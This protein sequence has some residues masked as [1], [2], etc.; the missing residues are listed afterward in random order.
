MAVEPLL[1]SDPERVHDHRLLARLGAG[2]MGVVYLGRS[3]GGRAVAIKVIRPRFAGDAEYR[4]RFRREAAAARTVTGTF[5]AAV[6]DADPEAAEP[7]LVTA[8]LPGLT[9][10]Q[11]IVTF[12][13]LPLD[14]V[15]TL[16]AGLAESL[17][18]IHRAGLAH[19]DLKPGNIVLTASGPRVIDFGIARQED[20]TAITRAGTVLGTPGFM[21]PEQV[22]GMVAGTAADVF[23]L[24]AVV[25]FA[26]TGREPFGTGDT[27]VVLRRV[28]AA[29]AD[30]A[31]IDD[32]V[33]SDLLATCLRVDQRERPPAVALLDRLGDATGATDATGWLPARVAEAID[34]HAAAARRVLTLPGGGDEPLD[35]PAQGASRS[36]MS[37]PTMDPSVPVPSPEPRRVSRRTVLIG[38]GVAVAAGA[39][40]GAVALL[41]DDEHRAAQD[42]AAR[43]S[44][45]GV[46]TRTGAAVEWRV[47]V[48]TSIPQLYLAGGTVLASSWGSVGIRA[49]DPATGALA[50]QR[51]AETVSATAGD[52]ALLVNPKGW[53]VSAVDGAT[54]S[55][56]WTYDP[57]AGEVSRS[58]V[59]AGSVVC[60]GT[61]MLR[62]IGAADGRPRWTADVRGE[63]GFVAAGDVLVAATLEKV[64]G[65][66]LDTGRVRWTIPVPEQPAD[67][68]A[69]NGIAYVCDAKGTIRA[70]RAADGVV[71]WQR[72][73]L[74]S[75]AFVWLVADANAMYYAADGEIRAF[76]A[77][78]GAPLWTRPIGRRTGAT[79]PY[80][81][82]DKS[83]IALVGD[84]LYVVSNTAHL[85]A[86]DTADGSVRWDHGNV[87][88]S[89]GVVVSDGLVLVG[90]VEGYVEAI[91]PPGGG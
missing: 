25:A 83:T 35:R 76:A 67:P 12:G 74:G 41:G 70:V 40:V 52:T 1:P 27:D 78:G 49:L 61:G 30:V 42:G 69:A 58:A 6:L 23:A 16:A 81:N 45:P 57:P 14:S 51:D 75:S 59:V 85:Y 53:R 17:A 10:R 26:A 90:T 15:R 11:T 39:V 77:A 19:R 7:W 38:G 29:D 22:N 21:A 71:G 20:A 86:L 18:D 5:T 64:T 68:Q 80:D 88:A 37:E 28:V 48:S 44:T 3:P 79:D 9:L 82:V 36:L 46:L 13:P 55:P 31:G 62:A 24:G 56:K 91:R 50:W 84:T 89:W 8:Y 54:G 32:R 34:R 2:G 65:V 66:D 73:G 63:R 87:A 47:K 4:A 33:L 72:P 60:F 43:S